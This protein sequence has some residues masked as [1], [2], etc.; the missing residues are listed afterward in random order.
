M[1][2]FK[3]PLRWS[4]ST[5]PGTEA[6]APTDVAPRR[7][8]GRSERG[9]KPRAPRRAGPRTG[10]PDR[11]TRPDQTRRCRRRWGPVR[12]GQQRG[13]LLAAPGPSDLIDALMGAIELARA[14]GGRSARP[15]K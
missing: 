3:T 4:L 11:H 7:P 6:L 12:P 13:A 10:A 14:I 5:L 9:I 8:L 1:Q 15:D 2:N